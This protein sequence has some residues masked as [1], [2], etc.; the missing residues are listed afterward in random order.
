VPHAFQQ[1]GQPFGVP[2]VGLAAGQVLDMP[3]V[4]SNTSR[5]SASHKAWKTGFQYTPVA[6]IATCVTPWSTSQATI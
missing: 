1:L 2:G 3:G 4:A 5:V 6:S